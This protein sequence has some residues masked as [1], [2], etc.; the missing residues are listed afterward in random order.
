MYVCKGNPYSF[1]I[2][3]AQHNTPSHCL[4]TVPT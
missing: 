4:I 1:F 2:P 3:N